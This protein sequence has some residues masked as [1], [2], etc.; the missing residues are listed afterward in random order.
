VRDARGFT[1]LEVLVAFVIA[2]LALGVMFQVSGDALKASQRAARYQD[3]LV[4]ARSHLAMAT[5]GGSLMPGNWDGDDGGGYRWHIHVVP[6]AGAAASAVAAAPAA[7]T[8]APIPAGRPMPPLVLYAVS[9]W[10]TWTESGHTRQVRL[11][12][13]Q[14]GEAVGGG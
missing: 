14:I 11:D 12:T 5:N 10:I 2:A 4:R 7:A 3:A 6:V 1:L 8:P 9:V 13:E